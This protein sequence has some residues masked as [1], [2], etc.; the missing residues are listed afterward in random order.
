LNIYH[1]KFVTSSSRRWASLFGS[2]T[3]N[4]SANDDNDQGT[5]VAGIDAAKDNSIGTAV[6]WP[7]EPSNGQFRYWRRKALVPY[8]L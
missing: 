8:Q 3:L 2:G 7:Q 4:T 6:G 5:H 1:Q